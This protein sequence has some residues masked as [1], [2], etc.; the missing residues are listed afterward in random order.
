MDD[1]SLDDMI[2]DIL[3]NES[4][5]G[6]DDSEEVE[7]EYY[8]EPDREDPEEMEPG[9]SEF[10]SLS[11][12]AEDSED[13]VADFLSVSK[14]DFTISYGVI[15]FG[16]L[17][18]PNPV[19]KDRAETYLG[20]SKSIGEIGIVTPIHVMISEGYSEYVEEY[21]TEEGFEGYKYILID[22]FRRVWAGYKNGL[23]R[24]YAV[25]WDFKDKDRGADLAFVLSRLV[26]K[27]G[28]HNWGEIWYMYQLLESQAAMTAG[29]LEYLLQ[30][31]PG[32][33]MKLKDI[34]QCEY[35]DII[36]DLLSNKKTLQQSYSALQKARKEEDVLRK[37]DAKGIAKMEQAEGIIDS[38]KGSVLSNEEVN[39]ILEMQDD[40]SGD[41]SAEDFDELMG[42]DI[43]DEVQ[44]VGDRHPLDPAL[45]AA[46]L[47]RDGFCCA[48]TGRGKGLPANIALS[49]LNVH[50]KVP[51]HCGGPD[52]MD[53]LITVC[54][55]AHTLIH[56]IE[57]NNGKLGMSQEQFESLPEDEK[58]FI[59]GVMKVARI[60]VEAN[61]K[62]GHTR[63][64][65]RSA[66]EKDVKFQMPGRVQRENMEALAVAK[67]GE[68]D[69]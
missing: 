44:N 17:L 66:T 51:V 5:G 16:S 46:V 10:N 4:E 49:I 22:G 32:D 64:E 57:R 65:V 69:V 3:G 67:A 43:P 45:R 12:S 33:A 34:M 40:F 20:L 9:E 59:T 27:T 29:T 60:A 11:A 13:K 37:E 1:A 58:V 55:D 31:E 6:S 35:Q 54:L 7:S 28:K 30:L 50:H 8:D 21:G 63:E 52:T 25:I 23:S 39:K 47:Q 61:R 68:N 62:L 48:I 56:I 15:E 26:N 18:I 41:L 14:D 36:A 53:N 38:S 42:N 24:A 2:E 19:K